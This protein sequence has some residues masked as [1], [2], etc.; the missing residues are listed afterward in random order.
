MKN[1]VVKL[2]L[3]ALFAVGTCQAAEGWLT[4][5]KKA[6][7]TAV[8]QKRPILADFTGSDWCG[9]C[10]KLDQEVFSQKEFQDYAKDNLVLFMADFP[11]QKTLPDA[12]RKQNETL[13]KK[14]KIQGFP[15]II[16]LDEKGGVIAKTGYQS[17]GAEAYVKHLKQL[18][19]NT[20][21]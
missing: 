8:E 7:K 3:I 15:T 21:K 14:Y 20:S 12:E 11:R 10:I 19:K 6:K 17:G 16:L 1:I 13:S 5:F 4:D 18:L 2:A 9:W